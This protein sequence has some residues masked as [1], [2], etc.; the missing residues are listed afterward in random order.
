MTPAA[1]NPTRG[2]GVTISETASKPV[3]W[4]ISILG[5][6]GASVATLTAS[7]PTLSTSWTGR[8]ATGPS[9]SARN[10]RLMDITPMP[11]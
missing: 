8:G 1:F 5:S 4:S 7:G 9:S 2:A 3:A 10:K 11:E 6:S